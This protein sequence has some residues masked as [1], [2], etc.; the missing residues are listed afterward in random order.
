MSSTLVYTRNDLLDLQPRH[1]SFVG[2]D[3]DGC[4]FPTME[5]KQKECFHSLI[6]ST[7]HLEGIE[8]YVREAAEFVNLHS[9]HRG[10]NRFPC[11]LKTFELLHNRPEARASG[12]ELPPLAPL[13][14]YCES[15]LALGNPT[16]ETYARE[17]RDPE[18]ARI[19]QWSKDV[20]A[21]V[22]E[23]VKKVP[24]FRWVI[25][26][27][28]E[29]RKHSDA[30]C[31]S[32]TPAEALIREWEANDL[33]EYV[34]VIAGQELGTKAEHLTMAT[35]G[36]YPADRVLMIGDAPGDLKAARQV[37]AHFFP[38]D[39]GHEEASWELFFKVAYALFLD[40]AYTHDYEAALVRRF[41]ALLPDTPPWIRT[42]P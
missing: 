17:T 37:G 23:V 20:N 36:R 9:R 27:L 19:L 31:V 30:I 15:G 8:R 7:W 28:K 29:I 35:Q 22:A 18:M 33:V 39:P 25:E 11:L 5:I 3:S 42:S 2:I 1:A 34:T 40:G 16:L 26:S 10:Q 24:P 38:I 4:I 14:R 21:R 12:I 41:E 6:V 32:Q 13:K